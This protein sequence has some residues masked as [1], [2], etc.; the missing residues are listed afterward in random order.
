M[1]SEPLV[2]A[3]L[4]FAKATKRTYCFHEVVVDGKE[5]A[6]GSVYLRQE[7]FGERKPARVQIVVYEMAADV[8]SAA[9]V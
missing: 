1:P 7:L 5:P 6:I 4:D 2:N 8:A 9:R 3:V